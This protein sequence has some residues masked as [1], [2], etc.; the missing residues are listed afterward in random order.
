M[1]VDDKGRWFAGTW[2]RVVAAAA[3]TGGAM[4]VMEQRARRGFSPPRH[5]HEREDTAFLVLEGLL[6]VVVGD[7]ER[8]VRAGELAWMPRG[9][10][11]TFRVDSEE[12]HLLELVTPGGVEGFHLDASDPALVAAIP[13]DSA[14]DVGRLVA[15]SSGY[16]IDIIGPPLA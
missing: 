6:T 9:V 8:A 13:A 14:V 2:L 7:A 10:P 15:S 3:D 5:V 16:G 4:T 1:D 12:V 11:H